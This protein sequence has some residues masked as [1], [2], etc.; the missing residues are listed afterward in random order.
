[1]LDL[2]PSRPPPSQ[3]A[4]NQQ[5]EHKVGPDPLKTGH[6]PA[7]QRRPT[8]ASKP[9]S[10]AK[11]SRK[12]SSAQVDRDA[13]IKRLLDN[14]DRPPSNVTWPR[15]CQTVRVEGD[16]FIGDPKNEKYKRGFT[17]DTIED[18]TRELMKSLA[19]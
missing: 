7:A 2:W 10:G 15:F 19:L 9:D 3:T 11:P 1:V 5:L 4:A 6:P 18:V 13:A 17:D 14:G 16:G 12:P 8:K